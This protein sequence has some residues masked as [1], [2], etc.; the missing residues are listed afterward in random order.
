MKAKK[1][2]FRKS[3]SI[4]LHNACLQNPTHDRNGIKY[5]GY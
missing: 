5:N 3:R 4:G 2:W 1:A